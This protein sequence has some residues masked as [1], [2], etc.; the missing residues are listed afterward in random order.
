M[1]DCVSLLHKIHVVILLRGLLWGCSPG[2]GIGLNLDIPVSHS[3]SE[4][5]WIVCWRCLAGI[6]CQGKL[7]SVTETPPMWNRDL[8]GLVMAAFSPCAI[9]IRLVITSIHGTDKMAATESEKSP[10]K[11]SC[12]FHVLHF[13][14]SDS[15]NLLIHSK[16]APPTTTTTFYN[17]PGTEMLFRLLLHELLKM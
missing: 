7:D 9:L 6:C 12:S 1:D 13:K 17:F 2:P 16:Y 11:I 15:V 5:H 10:H 14:V 8:W 4:F 3:S